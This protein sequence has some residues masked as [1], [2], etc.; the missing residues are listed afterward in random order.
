M[1]PYLSGE[2]LYGN[3]LDAVGIADWFRDEAEAYFQM[4]GDSQAAENYGY[5]ELN[6]QALFR[7]I[8]DRTFAHAIGLGAGRGTELLPIASRVGRLSVVESSTEYVADPTLPIPVTMVEAQPSG[9]LAFKAQAADLITSLGVLHHIPNVEHV[10]AELA[11]VLAPG[12]LALIREPIHSMGGD[13]G[14]PRQGLTPHERG[15]PLHLLRAWLKE[16]G[17]RITHETL[18]MFPPIGRLWRLTGHPPY[19][20]QTLTATDRAVCA[21]L[22]RNL[23][24]HATKWSEKLRPTSVALIAVKDQ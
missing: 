5:R 12:G 10:L 6:R 19:N 17:F 21:L 14:Q 23:R 2:R 1:N 22:K 15:I 24:Y 11:R 8:H 13:W 4:G 9:D 20:S 18:V 7:H 16:N 3:D